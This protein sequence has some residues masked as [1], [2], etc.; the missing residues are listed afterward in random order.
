M[1]FTCE[2]IEEL[3]DEAELT[4]REV[5]ALRQ[6][7]NLPRD[8]AGAHPIANVHLRTR[9]VLKARSKLLKAHRSREDKMR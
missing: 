2:Q 7:F 3:K 6:R 4:D 1:E 5:A 8:P 9:L